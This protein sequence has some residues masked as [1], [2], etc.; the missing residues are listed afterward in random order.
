MISDAYSTQQYDTNLVYFKTTIHWVRDCI[1][2]IVCQLSLLVDFVHRGINL[3][4]CSASDVEV[5]Q[6]RHSV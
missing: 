6:D 2:Y 4:H 3:I 1:R 5:K